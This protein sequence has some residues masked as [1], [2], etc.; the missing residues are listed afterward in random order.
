MERPPRPVRR[1]PHGEQP[2]KPE[3]PARP[4]VEPTR[5]D[6]ASL[7]PEDSAFDRQ[8]LERVRQYPGYV[9]YLDLIRRNKRESVVL[10]GAMILLWGVVGAVMGAA[11]G[12]W[13]HGMGEAHA[14]F[15]SVYDVDTSNP[16]RMLESLGENEARRRDSLQKTPWRVLGVNV[17]DYGDWG[18]VLPPAAMGLGIALVVACVGAAWSWYGG[19]QAILTMAGARPMRKEQ[20]PELFNV[21]EEMSLAAGIPMPRVFLIN[22]SALNAFATGRETRSTGRS[23]SRAGC[24][25]S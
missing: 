7:R 23:P 22:D 6:A 14:D 16:D 24:V 9:S 20:D 5:G 8:I 3:R 11:I 4:R 18:R 21:V 25:R 12:P 2:E 1:W 17:S 10:I 15:R 13:A 19:S